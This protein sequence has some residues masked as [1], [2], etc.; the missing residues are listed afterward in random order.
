MNCYSDIVNYFVVNLKSVYQ[1]KDCENLAFWSIHSVLGIN[2]S[3][4]LMNKN[5]PLKTEDVVVF[6]NII[7]QLLTNKPIQYV[8]EECE[9]Y[10]L[11]FKVNSNCLIPRPETE[12]LVHWILKEN[13]KSILD[14]GTGSGCIAICLAKY[15]SAKVSAMDISY[16]AL[17]LAK[18]NASSN[19]VDVEFIE[20]N[21]LESKQVFPKYDLIVSNPPYVL[22]SEKLQMKTNVLEFEPHLALFVEDDESLVF[23]EKIIDF[24]V[25]HLH[26]GGSLFFEINEQKAANIAQLLEENNFENILIKKDMQ[27]KDRMIK[28][29]MKL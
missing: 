10:N 19:N 23:Y 14:I 26:N 24:A 9:F 27:G 20:A 29:M 3:E 2:R 7:K 1:E 8:L 12:E 4:L 28:A 22:E 16:E 13:P 11:N 15:S 25:S 6:Q 5:T 17:S 21:I 18:Q